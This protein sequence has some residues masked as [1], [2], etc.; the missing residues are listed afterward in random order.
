MIT[1][2]QDNKNVVSQKNKDLI[3]FYGFLFGEDKK[4]NLIKSLKNH[5]NS[6]K[7]LNNEQF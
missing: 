2:E 6:K 5:L 1:L 7:D 4:E 3:K